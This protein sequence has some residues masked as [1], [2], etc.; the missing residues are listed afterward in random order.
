MTKAQ[1]NSIFLVLCVMSSLVAWRS[2]SATF[3]LAWRSD[4]YTHILLIL[5]VAA[6]LAFFEWP[7]SQSFSVANLRLGLPLL[8]AALVV[9][10]WSRWGWASRPADQHLALSMLALVAWWYGAFVLC[11]G[12]RTARALLF[13]LGF[14]LWLIPFPLFLL[15][16]I[17]GGLQ[18]GSAFVARVLFT[19]SGVPVTQDGI[20][21]TIPGLTIEVATECSSIRSSLMLLVTTMVLAHAFL[22][23][24]WRKILVVALAIPLSVAKN[25]LRIF[26]IAM[27]GTRVDPGFLTGKLHHQGGVVFFLIALAGIAALLWLLQRR[28]RRPLLGA[29][30]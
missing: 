3:S 4:E 10:S 16:W 8:L 6:V 25:G 19:A 22:R 29:A 17:V 2:V 13:P 28:E 23:A 1:A 30:K 5:P 24:P 9:A 26:T 18:Y 20:L 15:D 21:L 7:S 11:F 12:I 14:L 27:L